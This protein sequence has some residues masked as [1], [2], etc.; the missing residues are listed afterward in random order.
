M[1]GII[2]G[3]KSIQLATLMNINESAPLSITFRHPCQKS[4]QSIRLISIVQFYII[5]GISILS[6]HLTHLHVHVADQ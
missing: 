2:L 5:S 3:G 4:P 6:I 1:Y